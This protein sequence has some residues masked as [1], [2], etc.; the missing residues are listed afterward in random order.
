[1]LGVVA[2]EVAAVIARQPEPLPGRAF[3]DPAWQPA[4]S[5]PAAGRTPG[6]TADPIKAVSWA[7]FTG[8]T[9]AAQLPEGVRSA[10]VVTARLGATVIV[11]SL[12]ITATQLDEDQN[13]DPVHR[14]PTPAQGHRLILFLLEV[15]NVG[16]TDYVGLPTTFA[17]L[18]DSS[19]QWSDQ[20]VADGE[21][22]PL[23]LHPDSWGQRDLVFEVGASTKPAR[24]RLALQPGDPQQ[25]VDW[26][27]G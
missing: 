14:Y 11:R 8:P 3:A 17:W 26:V 10:A 22:V 24:L 7:P 5:P 27:L 15:R 13:P 20:T 16:T 19:G 12:Q 2:A 25:T 1:M 21:K 6:P 23:R 4:F 9:R 18:A